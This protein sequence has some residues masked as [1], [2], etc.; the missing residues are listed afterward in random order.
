MNDAWGAIFA[1]G[2]G[3]FCKLISLPSRWFFHRMCEFVCLWDFN[4][5][6]A[7]WERGACVGKSAEKGVMAENKCVFLI[8]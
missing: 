3:S 1:E 4:L 8:D 5:L 6:V 7:A 2:V